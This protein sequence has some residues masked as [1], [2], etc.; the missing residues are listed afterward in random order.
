MQTLQLLNKQ[1][2]KKQHMFALIAH[3]CTNFQHIHPKSNSK[4][5]IIIKITIKG[6]EIQLNHNINHKIK[7]NNAN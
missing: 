4:Q 5:K 2:T 3:V 6:A 7:I 1:L